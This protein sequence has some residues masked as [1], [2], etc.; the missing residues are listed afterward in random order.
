MDADSWNIPYTAGKEAR[1]ARDRG[2][3][4][5]FTHTAPFGAV[6]TNWERYWTKIRHQKAPPLLIKN[7]EDL[8]EFWR[9]HIE[10]IR[11]EKLD[12]IWQIGF[13]G[14]GD[15]PFW[16]KTYADAMD[17][18]KADKDRAAIIGTMLGEQVAL[19]KSVIGEVHPL[20]KITIYNEGSDFLAAGLLHLPEEPNLI[21]NYAAARADHYPPPELQNYTNSGGTQP[22]GYYMN[23]QFTGTGSHLAPAEGPWKMEQNFRYV[24]EKVKRPLAFSVVNAGNIR[25]HVLELSANAAMMWNFDSYKTD[26]YL[27]EYAETYFGASRKAEVFSLY[28]DFYRAYWSPRKSDL[29]GFDRQYLFQ[30]LRY[31]KALIQLFAMWGHPYTENPFND[32]NKG[33]YGAMATGGRQF[34]IVPADHHAPDQVEAAIAGTEQSA[35]AFGAVA[36]RAELL[37]G[38]LSG[39]QKPFFNDDLRL[40]A[41]FMA[42]LNVALNHA[43][44]AYKEKSQ[45]KMDSCKTDLEACMKSLIELKEIKAKAD[46]DRFAEWYANEKNF[47]FSGIEKALSKILLAP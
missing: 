34:N 8:K 2:L 33:L 39:Q 13:R 40:Q 12:V 35:K 1:Y 30:D 11:K 42:E 26:D 7:V 4:I 16:R 28:Q 6:L 45:G 27:K 29:A 14:M 19:L 44:L 9:Y 21:L 47:D 32:K 20:L 15:K 24:E 36:G 41:M 5:S 37:Y 17:E 18:P 25:E 10:T 3:K 23:F 46:H 43:V 31:S 22:I 38:K